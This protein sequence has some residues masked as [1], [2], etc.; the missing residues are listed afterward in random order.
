MRLSNQHKSGWLAQVGTTDHVFSEVSVKNIGL[1][2]R[3]G[4]IA[5]AQPAKLSAATLSRR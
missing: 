2:P 5:G 1:V 4:V 3:V